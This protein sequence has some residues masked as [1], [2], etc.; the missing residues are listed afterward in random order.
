MRVL[1]LLGVAALASIAFSTTNAM[2]QTQNVP[3][4]CNWVQT[5][6][7]SGPFTAIITFQ[8]QESGGNVAA[9]RSLTYTAPSWQ[10]SNCSIS[11]ASGVYNSGSCQS[12]SLYR[13][14]PIPPSLCAKAG[15]YLVNLCANSAGNIPV[16]SACGSNCSLRFETV[17]WTSMCPA[18]G[19][20]RS[21]E[22]KVFCQ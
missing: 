20:G 7:Q 21:P 5:G 6:S 19:E 10:V 4:S 2:A 14:E 12:A 22:V 16:Q 18:V 11:L 8:C 15:T 13:I 17:G 9:T 3:V 1:K